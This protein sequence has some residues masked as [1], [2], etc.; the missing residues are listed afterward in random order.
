MAVRYRRMYNVRYRGIDRRL[1]EVPEGTASISE[2]QVRRGYTQVLHHR[3]SVPYAVQVLQTVAGTPSAL[4]RCS[5][6]PRLSAGGLRLSL[7]L[8]DS[9]L[10][11]IPCGLFHSTR[12]SL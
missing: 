1:Y 5:A 3:Y 10:P 8:P 9:V 6:T 7:G 4:I 2:R 11:V 12:C